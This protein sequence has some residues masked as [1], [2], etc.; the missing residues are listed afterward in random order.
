MPTQAEN[1]KE[2][3]DTIKHDN[4]YLTLNPG[5]ISNI[6]KYKINRTKI[7]TLQRH[8]KQPG[9]V[10]KSNLKYIRTTDFNDK[11]LMPNIRIATLNARLVKYKDQIIVQELTNNGMNAALKKETWTKDTQEDLAWLNL[12]EL[13]QGHYEISTHN[14]PGEKGVVVL[15]ETLAGTTS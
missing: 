7:N 1:L 15:H 10:N 6:C 14:R 13:C 8:G 9:G 12:S 11:D 3:Q 4:T 2:L 5:A